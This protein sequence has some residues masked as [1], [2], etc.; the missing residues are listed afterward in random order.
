[1]H[2]LSED[3]EGCIHFM[4]I[5]KARAKGIYQDIWSSGFYV[6]FS[7]TAFEFTSPTYQNMPFSQKEGKEEP[8]VGSLLEGKD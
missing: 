1:M 5:L 2:H 3:D 6:Q 8:G 7:L 4:P